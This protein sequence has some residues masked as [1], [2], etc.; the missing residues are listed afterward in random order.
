MLCPKCHT[1]FDLPAN[2]CPQCGASLQ[3]SGGRILT[4]TAVIVLMIIVGAYGYV[5]FQLARAPEGAERSMRTT[6]RG[7]SADRSL[8]DRRQAEKS[9]VQPSLPSI[10]AAELILADI[11]GR[12]I[13][14]TPVAVVAPGWF[15]LPAHAGIGAY[16]WRVVM[17]SGRR[18]EVEGGILHNTSPVG[19]WQL[20]S[21]ASQGQAELMPWSP[22][23]PLTWQSLVRPETPQSVRIG[24][25]E[26]LVDFVRIPFDADGD[27]LGVFMQNGQVVGWSFGPL[28]PGGY[29]WTGNRGNDLTPEFY[30]DDFYRL[31]FAGSREEA[32]ILALAE[33]DLSD[34]QRLE[35][36]ASA[37]RLEPRLAPVERPAH[38][39]PAAIQ[40]A[41]RE[42][43]SRLQNQ[44]EAEELLALFDPPTVLTIADSSLTADLLTVALELGAYAYANELIDAF[45]EADLGQDEQGRD[46]RQ[47]QAELY[48]DWLNRLMADGNIDDARAVHREAAGRF[49]GDPAIHLAGVELALQNQDWV[50]AERLL[51][52]RNYPPEMRDRVGRLQQ[53]IAALRGQEGKIVVRFR[54]GARTIP[55]VA[56]VGRE[57]FD[58]RFVIDT[59]ASIVTVP[60]ATAKRLGI[61]IADDLPR[62]LFYS[63][64]GV[65]HAVEITLPYIELDGWVIE[66]VKALVVDLPGQSEVGLLGM[67]YLNNFRMDVNTSEG[68][69]LLEPR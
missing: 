13:L 63:A 34:L 29:L 42:L 49:P 28:M 23:Q 10:I 64:T 7:G 24:P 54:P 16:T 66:N 55:V 2:F 15:A 33:E 40:A 67:N 50:R 14:S 3:R 57:L 17:A 47:L 22:E 4:I 12:Q 45:Q 18:F 53:A 65:Q 20:S 41:M 19:L 35:N 9:S 38:I 6:S 48:R 60:S 32:L 26:Y 58:Q 1:V 44:D 27:A 52:A 30:P 39:A 31:T 8:S 37:Y 68:V 43:V 69:L 11:S 51:A 62:R 61:D 25:T 21:T 5:H 46:L 59:G 36:L 56:R